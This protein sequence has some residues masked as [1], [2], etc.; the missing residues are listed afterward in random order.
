MEAPCRARSHQNGM[1][2]IGF[3]I[4]SGRTGY[5]VR[6]LRAH[7]PAKSLSIHRVLGIQAEA[8]LRRPAALDYWHLASC[9]MKEP[10]SEGKQGGWVGVVGRGV[11]NGVVLRLVSHS[12]VRLAAA[13]EAPRLE[14]PAMFANFG[15]ASSTFEVDHF[16][17]TW[18][19][20]SDAL[21]RTLGHPLRRRKHLS[22]KMT[23]SAQRS[24]SSTSW[25]TPEP[26][27]DSKACRDHSCS[28]LHSGH[29]HN[30]SGN[31]HNV[32]L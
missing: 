32:T 5:S 11:P 16:E 9:T 21:R 29:V 19:D 10:L 7:F 14:T 23:D 25:P 27:L 17:A 1:P 2:A 3:R 6:P 4:A 20:D 30:V 15:P 24:R 31:V 12:V 28:S 8:S 18:T 13:M 26:P 22:R